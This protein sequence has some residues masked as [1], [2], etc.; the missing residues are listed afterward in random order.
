MCVVRVSHSCRF[1]THAARSLQ[2]SD[3]LIRLVDHYHYV[4]VAIPA[5]AASIRDMVK[6]PQSTAQPEGLK[7]LAELGPYETTIAGKC[8]GKCPRCQKAGLRLPMGIEGAIAGRSSLMSDYPLREFAIE[9][10]WAGNL[11]K[12]TGE[13]AH[14]AWMGEQST[15]PLD[16]PPRMTPGQEMILP[17]YMMGVPLGESQ[18]D[19][20]V[21][22]KVES[23]G[24]QYIF[25]F[26]YLYKAAHGHISEWRNRRSPTALQPGNLEIY[27]D[28]ARPELLAF[29]KEVYIYGANPLETSPPARS[30]QVPYASE[31][32]D[33][34]RA[35]SDMSGALLKAA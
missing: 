8:L 29:V 33:P 27:T 18:Y 23:M 7:A 5:D 35:A 9:S 24:G 21:W 4:R 16:H 26:G 10:P 30:A 6:S 32:G 28:R 14:M 20:S 17:N 19:A 31:R 2:K 34:G 11:A 22:N 13:N 3:A 12:T 1:A 15:H 25:P